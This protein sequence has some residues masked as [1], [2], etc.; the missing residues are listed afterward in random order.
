MNKQLSLLRAPRNPPA[1][2]LTYAELHLIETIEL[3]RDGVLPPALNS[4][5]GSRR[6]ILRRLM[7]HGFVVVTGNAPARFRVSAI[8][9]RARQITKER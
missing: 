7:E 4:S 6:K 2:K 5:A 3:L 1:R 8:G 9:T